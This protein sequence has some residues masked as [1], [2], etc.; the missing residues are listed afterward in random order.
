MTESEQKTSAEGNS[1]SNTSDNTALAPSRATTPKAEPTLPPPSDNVGVGGGAVGGGGEIDDDM[2]L[3]TEFPPPPYYYTL[4]SRQTPSHMKLKPPEIPE[5]AFRVAAKKV[6]A[7][8]R[9]AREESERI[10]MEAEKEESGSAVDGGSGGGETNKMDV[11]KTDASVA[12]SAVESTNTARSASSVAK[13]EEDDDSIDPDDPNEPVVAVFG[14]IVEDPTLVM[15]EECHDPVEIREN[16]KRL[17]QA[18][19]N[20]FLKLVQK[21]VHDPNDNKKLRDELS[22]NLF[23]MLQECN[24][25][26]EHQAR[27]ILID[28]L[29][30]QLKRREE[31]LKML[32]TQI[33]EA[34]EALEA[35][36]KFRKN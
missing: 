17:N 27:E 20:G 28:T 15:E 19:L 5:R 7:E 9:K 11:D 18:V 10:R 2:L 36:R 35:L 21:L 4:A 14:E 34:D 3:V 16:V 1:P 12:S 25:F 29:E 24:K 6:M 13:K 32:N 30:Q 33:G 23:L 31:G 22:H 26:R 8:R